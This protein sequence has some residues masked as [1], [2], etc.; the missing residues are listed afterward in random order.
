MHSAELNGGRWSTCKLHVPVHTGES[1]CIDDVVGENAQSSDPS[2][3][4]PCKAL[5]YDTCAGLLRFAIAGAA[6]GRCETRVATHSMS[7]SPKS[8]EFRD[9][10][11][12]SRES[13]DATR[14]RVDLQPT[15][16]VRQA[17]YCRPRH[18]YPTAIA[19]Q[20]AMLDSRPSST[21][22]KQC[23]YHTY[24]G[25]THTVYSMPDRTPHANILRNYDHVSRQYLPAAAPDAHQR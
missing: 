13:R 7:N 15:V 12:A 8:S 18:V 21:V 23:T 1:S 24:G 3:R 17:W 5:R 6:P 20:S 9:G 4:L 2:G 22:G 16:Q 10:R 25:Y 14:G 11:P 19:V